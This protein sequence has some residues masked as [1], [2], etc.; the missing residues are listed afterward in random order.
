MVYRFV[1]EISGNRLGNVGIGDSA[2]GSTT[3]RCADYRFAV[4]RGRA[5][6]PALAGR[7]RGFAL[8][9]GGRALRP[10]SLSR[11]LQIAPQLLRF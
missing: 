5:K 9:P 10:N 2:T 3:V 11:P 7:S 8:P 1:T 6:R 4:I